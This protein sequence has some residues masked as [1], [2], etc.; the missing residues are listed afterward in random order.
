LSIPQTK[1]VTK[2]HTQS[3]SPHKRIEVET[4]IALSGLKWLRENVH[5]PKTYGNGG[6]EEQIVETLSK[7]NEEMGIY[8]G[9]AHWG[10][11]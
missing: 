3:T 7:L 11:Y 1:T 6:V 8:F 2:E 9:T 5:D 10:S 4:D